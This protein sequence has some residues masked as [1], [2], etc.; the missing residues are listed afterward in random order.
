[1]AKGLGLGG[2]RGHAFPLAS[3]TDR[4]GQES[5]PLCLEVD[6]ETAGVQ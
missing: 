3:V 2:Q 1:M 4:L 6:R 5:C